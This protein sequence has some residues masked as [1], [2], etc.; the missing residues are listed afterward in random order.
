MLSTTIYYFAEVVTYLLLI[1]AI[2]SWVVRDYSN[3]FVQMII[4]MTEPIL[5][6]MRILFNKLGWD[7]GMI[8]FSFLATYFSV[9][10]LSTILIRIFYNM[11]L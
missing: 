2:M 9:K 5:E 8:D 4:Q 11:G 3:R 6:P 1:R 7:R 10:I